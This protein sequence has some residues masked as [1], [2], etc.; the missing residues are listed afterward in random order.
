MTNKFT[1]TV[2]EFSHTVALVWRKL[3]THRRQF[4]QRKP[5]TNSDTVSPSLARPPKDHATRVQPDG[6]GQPKPE[7]RHEHGT[8]KDD[9][10]GPG[11]DEKT[12]HTQ[13]ETSPSYGTRGADL[14]RLPHPRG[15]LQADDHVAERRRGPRATGPEEAPRRPRGRGE[16]GGRGGGAVPPSAAAAAP[17]ES[18]ESMFD[19]ANKKGALEA[20]G[21]LQR[22]QGAGGLTPAQEQA[23]Y[24]EGVVRPAATGNAAVDELAEMATGLKVAGGVPAAKDSSSSPGHKFPLPE[25][26]LPWHMQMKSRYHPVL[27]QLSRLMMREGKLSKAQSDLAK[28]LNILR[29]SPP[30]ILSPKYPLLPGSPPAH[31]LP[32]NPIVYLTLAIDSVAPLMR[33]RHLRGVVGG[34]ASLEMPLPL[35]VRQRRRIAFQWILE[36]VKK[37]PSM[38]SGSGQFAHKLASEI[39]A[40]VEGRSA[41]WDKRGQVHKIATSARANLDKNLKRSSKG[42]K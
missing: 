8:A 40:V 14:A 30:P 24:E 13:H 1:E 38:G 18:L 42:G 31:H 12:T 10:P 9:E 35:E 33:I 16:E 29:T 3:W 2:E 34:G 7:S 28:V 17:K 22:S 20:H 36:T 15:T 5:F 11:I 27:D 19:A 39:I 41:V 6:R 25:L 21:L 37:R 26:P 32:L 4:C 23:L